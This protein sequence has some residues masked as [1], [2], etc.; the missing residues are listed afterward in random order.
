MPESGDSVRVSGVSILRV[1]VPLC[2]PVQLEFVT[3]REENQTAYGTR[4]IATARCLITDSRR[5]ILP[6]W[7][8][9]NNR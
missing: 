8:S 9:R 5:R 3:K 4:E 2:R 6:K 1:S 7:F